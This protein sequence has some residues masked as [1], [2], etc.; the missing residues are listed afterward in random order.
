MEQPEAIIFDFDG[1]LVDLDR[2]IESYT[3]NFLLKNNISTS[4]SLKE[5]YQ[6]INAGTAD[7]DP[8]LIEKFKA[9]WKVSMVRD[10]P[11]IEGV[12]ETVKSLKERGF[13]LG[14]VSTGYTE[15]LNKI[16]EAKGLRKYFDILIGKEDVENQKPDPEGIL[17]AI[18]RLVIDPEKAFY[19]GDNQVDVI[20]GKAAGVKTA[21]L[22]I[23][24]PYA[25]YLKPWLEENKPDYIIEGFESLGQKT[26]ILP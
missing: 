9:D 21:F 1:T 25:E 16:L 15:R 5:F 14:I 4:L 19:V 23:N 8:A 11:L 12:E 18:Q 3:G 7:L 13:K 26:A 17:K 2:F 10:I 20:A 24:K 22:A 6:E